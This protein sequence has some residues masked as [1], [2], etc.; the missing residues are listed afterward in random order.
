MTAHPPIP[1]LESAL[2]RLDQLC[3]TAETLG[4]AAPVAERLVLIAD[5]EAA[6]AAMRTARTEI[7]GR[8]ARARKSAPAATAY[9]RAHLLRPTHR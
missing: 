1:R 9:G 7:R 6:L 4:R 8:L 5:L 3:R 2:T